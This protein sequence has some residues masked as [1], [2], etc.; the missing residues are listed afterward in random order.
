MH[1]GTNTALSQKRYPTM[2]LLQP[3]VDLSQSLLT[4]SHNIGGTGTR[5]LEVN[6]EDNALIACRPSNVCGEMVQVERYTD[7][8]V[9]GFFTDA[10][11]V[12][13]TLARFPRSGYE[14]LSQ[15]RQSSGQ[16]HNPELSDQRSIALSNE[17]PILLVSRS[18]VNRLNE[19]IKQTGGVGEDSIRRL[20]PWQ[21][22]DCRRTWPWSA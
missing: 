7:I 16:A 19:N 20:L 2:A 13:C 15:I 5:K 17:S 11:G 18:S 3:S 14:R 8:K 12:P 10:L 9:S 4:I 22:C 21:H 6:L 1:E